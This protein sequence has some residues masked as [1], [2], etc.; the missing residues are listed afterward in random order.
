MWMARVGWSVLLAVSVWLMT[1][2]MWDRVY[3]EPTGDAIATA[4]RGELLIG[5][6]AVLALTLAASAYWLLGVTWWGAALAAA[7][8]TVCVA[9][10]VM[11]TAGILALLIAYPLA[12]AS[13]VSVL[14]GPRL[15]RPTAQ[16]AP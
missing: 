4:R 5:A 12:L 11:S 10:S 6:G 3:F 14:A 2:G 8:A 16:P 9:A 7:A 15:Q 13:A 1:V